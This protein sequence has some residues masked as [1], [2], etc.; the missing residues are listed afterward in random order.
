MAVSGMEAPGDEISNPEDAEN[1]LSVI[2][3]ESGIDKNIIAN[4]IDKVHPIGATLDNKQQR[5][6]K[7]KSDSFKE[8]IYMAQKERKKRDKRRRLVNFKQSFTQRRIELLSNANYKI[9][10]NDSVKFIYA[11]MHGTL[12][13]VLQNSLK[14]KFVHGFNTEIELDKILSKLDPRYQESRESDVE[15]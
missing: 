3:T 13:T 11:D 2:A 4:N 12:K 8:K 9:K 14:R 5:I 15:K 6:V 10:D 7:F 1:V